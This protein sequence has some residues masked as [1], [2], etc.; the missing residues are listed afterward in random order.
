MSKS[1]PKNPQI[2]EAAAKTGSGLVVYLMEE[3]TDARLR[4]V[5][6]K[7]YVDQATKL[8]GESTHRDHFFEVAGQLIHGIPETLMKLDKALS[9]SSLAASRLDYEEL[10]QELKPEKLQELEHVLDDVRI[11]YL[12]RRSTEDDTMS[13]TPKNA[14]ERLMQLADDAEVF[15]DR[16]LIVAGL[17]QLLGS[18][19]APTKTASDQDPTKLLRAVAASLVS[20]KKVN[21]TEVIASLRQILAHTLVAQAKS[22][23]TSRGFLAG[24]MEEADEVQNKEARFFPPDQDDVR[25][26]LGYI[27]DANKALAN[28]MAWSD[29]YFKEVDEF[30]AIGDT[31]AKKAKSDALLL[32]RTLESQAKFA[33]KDL[34]VL[35]KHCQELGADLTD[36][37]HNPMGL[38]GEQ[39]M[40]FTASEGG[41]YNPIALEHM[42]S[43]LPFEADSREEVM[44]GFKETN[45]DMSE[46]DLEAAADQWEKNRNVVK[47]KTGDPVDATSEKQAGYSYVRA[48]YPM[49][50]DW[51]P[52]ADQEEVKDKFKEQNPSME[53][54]D[55]EEVADAWD[56][57][58]DVVKDK[59]ASYARGAAVK[60]KIEGQWDEM[61]K[62]M[63]DAGL[64]NL[65]TRYG[66][67]G[68]NFGKQGGSMMIRLG[69]REA[70]LTKMAPD[71]VW[72]QQDYELLS[73]LDRDKL[74]KWIDLV[75]NAPTMVQVR[76]SEK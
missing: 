2:R 43:T 52:L 14:S 56:E 53:Q 9:A 58:K 28:L 42:V 63:E 48:A 15:S 47:E 26:P 30:P 34:T 64:K 49:L 24:V 27:K 37:F 32:C 74:A 54:D 66:K 40:D 12:N 72:G 57:N 18:L 36:A 45:P 22:E 35:A 13:I 46:E 19:E 1:E 4:C 16:N 5:Q 8:V 6:L 50:A 69:N 51:E 10:K 71:G 31:P 20:S 7:R 38:G 68:D 17:I 23:P 41:L 55:L 3:L 29:N 61:T 33:M 21:R 62:M 73:K 59:E 25:K 39:V 67:R 70:S 44:K 75:K 60:W 65:G 11:R 76:N